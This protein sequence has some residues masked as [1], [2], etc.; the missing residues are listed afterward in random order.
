VAT[1]FADLEARIRGL[2]S[3]QARTEED[4]TVI[5]TTVS[6]TALK[7]EWLTQ[8]MTAIAD[9]LGVELPPMEEDDLE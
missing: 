4:T 8:A 5:I 2:E 3:R 9:R 7:V 6:D 1:T